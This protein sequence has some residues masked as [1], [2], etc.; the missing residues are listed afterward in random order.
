MYPRTALTRLHRIRVNY[1]W[2]WDT[3]HLP[4]SLSNFPHRL[5]DLVREFSKLRLHS[6]HHLFGWSEK[7]M[8]IEIQRIP[9]SLNEDIFV[10]ATDGTSPVRIHRFRSPSPATIL[11]YLYLCIILYVICIIHT[12]RRIVHFIHIESPFVLLGHELIQLSR[13]RV[14]STSW[15]YVSELH[16]I[17]SRTCNKRN[18]VHD[19]L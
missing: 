14:S 4:K 3:G 10:V 8:K 16:R 11:V 9:S 13:W 17:V 19:K 1:L 18:N 7:K 5:F 6:L 2:H 15:F 12:S